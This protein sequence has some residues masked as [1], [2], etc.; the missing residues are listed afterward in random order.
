MQ[1]FYFV[2]YEMALTLNDEE[3]TSRCDNQQMVLPAP[4]TTM[5]QI[6]FLEDRLVDEEQEREYMVAPMSYV[7]TISNYILLRTEPDEV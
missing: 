1:Y 4:I 7:A 3:L 2:H 6:R 5:E